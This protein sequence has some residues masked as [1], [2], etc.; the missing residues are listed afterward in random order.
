MDLGEFN[1]WVCRKSPKVVMTTYHDRSSRFRER[2]PGG[3][4]LPRGGMGGGGGLRSI[5]LWNSAFFREVVQSGVLDNKWC[6]F[7]CPSPSQ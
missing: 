6:T 1:Q 2:Q 4:C 3:H 5:P 7:C